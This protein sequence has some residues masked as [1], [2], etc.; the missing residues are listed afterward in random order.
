MADRKPRSR[1]RDKVK[2]RS[3]SLRTV[4][5]GGSR[6]APARFR[7]SRR[8]VRFGQRERLCAP[9]SGEATSK[10]RGPYLTPPR[11][12]SGSWGGGQD[13]AAGSSFLRSF[14][15]TIRRRKGVL[16]LAVLAGVAVGWAYSAR[17]PVTY[18]AE[19]TFTLTDYDPV[20]E[21]YD[22]A[23]WSQQA[24][25][26]WQN[27]AHR[28]KLALMTLRSRSFIRR[29]LPR[30][31]PDGVA[32]TQTRIRRIQENLEADFREESS[33]LRIRYASGDPDEPIR[34]LKGLI[35]TVPEWLRNRRRESL[36]LALSTVQ[37]IRSTKSIGSAKRRELTRRSRVLRRALR[38]LEIASGSGRGIYLL[39]SSSPEPVPPAYGRNLLLGGGIGLLIGLLLVGL[40]HRLDPV[41]RAEPDLREHINRALLGTLPRMDDPR[42]DGLPSLG[43][44]RDTEFR[45][46]VDV[47]RSRLNARLNGGRGAVLL[48]TSPREGEG[49]STVALNLSRAFARSDQTTLL[50]DFDLRRGVLHRVFGRSLDPGAAGILGGQC[51]RADAVRA[52]DGFDLI[53]GG[54]PTMHP[55]ELFASSR[56]EDV[57]DELR[58]D[59]D[60]IVLDGPR[61]EGYADVREL[62]RVIDGTLLVVQAGRTPHRAV[63][64]IC[65]EFDRFGVPLLGLVLNEGAGESLAGLRKA[66]VGSFLASA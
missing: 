23:A 65:G 48:I 58:P 56:L 54:S 3:P 38:I 10:G 50:V 53:T 18:R 44:D 2:Y 57:M 27:P 51:T 59:Y 63:D 31:H 22:D 41:F 47:L 37:V 52:S 46:Q 17:R 7:A 66:D 42:E 43:A 8:F 36:R 6:A 62:G 13:S 45:R 55:A 21:V 15:Q 12:S 19:A 25:S 60:R 40:R 24:L 35:L 16:L 32:D 34:V 1:G 4:P 14:L 61:V 30:I 5:F 49:K 64:R 39:R 9:L 26:I 11:S 28:G 33:Y 20:K 29:A